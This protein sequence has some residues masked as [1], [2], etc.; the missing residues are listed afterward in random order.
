M[1][2]PECKTCK[3]WAPRYRMESQSYP[4]L[5]TT[6]DSAEPYWLGTCA[7]RAPAPGGFTV[8][9]AVWAYTFSDDG[10]W[11]HKETP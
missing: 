3:F 1:T 11:E 9:R 2:P 4:R 10:C 7:K 5:V 6:T 8:E